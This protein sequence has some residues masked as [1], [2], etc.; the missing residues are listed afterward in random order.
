MDYSEPV[1]YNDIKVGHFHPPSLLNDVP[2]PCP[3]WCRV[4]PHT[5]TFTEDVRHVGPALPPLL[6]PIEG[7]D[8]TI[9]SVECAARLLGAQLYAYTEPDGSMSRP[10]VWVQADSALG[11]FGGRELEPTALRQ[12][13][14]QMRAHADGLEALADRCETAGG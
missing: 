1:D 4:G 6:A 12:L 5:D 14:R 2:A 7:P 11:Q 3:P 8:G 9:D 13:V 10:T